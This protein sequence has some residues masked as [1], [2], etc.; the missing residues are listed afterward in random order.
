VH[1][2]IY[3]VFITAGLGLAFACFCCFNKGHLF[4]LLFVAR[5]FEVTGNSVYKISAVNCTERLVSKMT[6]CV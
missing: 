1:T 4:V 5:V 3:E 6:C 2:H